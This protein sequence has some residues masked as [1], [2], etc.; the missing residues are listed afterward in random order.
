MKAGYAPPARYGP[1]RQIVQKTASLKPTQLQLLC[2]VLLS[3][4]L[5]LVLFYYYLVHSFKEASYSKDTSDAY[6]FLYY[7]FRAAVRLNRLLHYQPS[8]Y[9][10]YVRWPNAGGRLGVEF[11]FALTTV[12]LG[13]LFLTVLRLARNFRNYNKVLRSLGGLVFLFAFPLTYVVL[14]NRSYNRT[15]ASAFSVT[16]PE[17][18]CAAVLFLIYLLRPFSAWGMGIVLLLH[19]CLWALV[20]QGSGPDDTLYGPI[21][22]RLL[23]LLIPIGGAVWLYYCQVSRRDSKTQLSEELWSKQLL[24]AVAMSVAGL[25]ALWLPGRG[26]SLAHAKNRDSLTI[27]MSRSTCQMGCPV[28]K[29]TVHGNGEVEYA[30]EQFVKVRGAQASSLNEEQMQAALVGFDRADF[31]SLEDQ[32]FAWG[33]H[34]A[35]VSVRITVDGKTKEVSSDTYHIGAKSGLQAKF[36]DATANLDRIIGTD[37]WIKCDEARCQP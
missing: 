6:T 1:R 24:V 14:S 37:R 16:I 15:L 18:L 13:V 31:F 17:L 21:P 2:E 35:G 33:Y 27:E 22:P 23:L 5:A 20:Y 10:K 19:Y 12:F 30:G 26:Y 11:A 3:L 36:V 28:Y 29:I 7:F 34:S 25:G 9:E 4:N 32:A 8:G